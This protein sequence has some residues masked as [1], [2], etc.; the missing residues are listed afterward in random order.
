VKAGFDLKMQGSHKPGGAIPPGRAAYTLI[1]L[2]VVV[3]IIAILASLLLPALARAKVEGKKAVCISNFH[4]LQLAW[5]LYTDDHNDRFPLNDLRSVQ[6]EVESDPNWVAGWMQRQDNWL[7]NTN[8]TKMIKTFGGIGSYL[9]DVKIFKCPSDQSLAKI[10]GRQLPRVRSVAMND[11][12]GGQNGDIDPNGDPTS[13]HYQTSANL[14]AHPPLENGAVFID[15]HE[16]SIASGFFQVAPPFAPWWEGFPGNRHAGA[17]ISFSD[18]HVICHRW[19]DE[20]T[21]MPISGVQ[22]PS[23]KQPGNK[24]IHWLQ[25]RATAV[26]PNGMIYPPN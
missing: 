8:G 15:T 23:M 10:G 11:Y 21:K 2:L 13:Y 12:F 9:N 7:D 1:E 14:L 24:D 26:K 18:G 19:L 4:Q 20:R 16:D 25:E 6:G 3:A 22:L 5:Q 17:T